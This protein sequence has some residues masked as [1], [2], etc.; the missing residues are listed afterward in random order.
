MAFAAVPAM[1]QKVPQPSEQLQF[2]AEDEGVKRPVKIPEEV[3][4]ILR[5]DKLVHNV[6]EDQELTA[7]KLPS[8]WFSAAECRLGSSRQKDLIVTA[9]GPLVGANINPTGYPFDSGNPKG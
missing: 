7:E 1:G 4:A 9:V 8:A 3:L 2:S 5:K 6:L